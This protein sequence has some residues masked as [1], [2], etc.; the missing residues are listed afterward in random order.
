MPDELTN[1]LPLER[2]RSVSR[3]YRF[4]LG[5]VALMLASALIASA[6]ILLTPTYIFLVGSA[7]AK[8]V[9][10]AHMKATLSASDEAALSARLTALSNDA[11][12][13]IALSDRPA[14][15]KLVSAALS[16][17]RPGI[18]VSS[19]AYVPA[20]GKNPATLALSGRAATRNALRNYQLAL[21]EAPFASAANV[22]VSAYAKDTDITFTITVTLLP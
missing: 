17:P 16:V 9:Q 3:E 6:A 11:K 8:E 18:A 4:R 19:I 7:N 1:L 14:V 21:E 22:P 10:L 5:V 20:T 15:S 2:D 12:A 13:L